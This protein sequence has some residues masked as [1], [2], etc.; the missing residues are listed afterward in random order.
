MQ[1]LEKL[2][3]DQYSRTPSPGVED[4]SYAHASARVRA[5]ETVMLGKSLLRD[6][7]NAQNFEDSVEMLT[8]TEYA[9]NQPFT[10]ANAEQKL[11]DKRAQNKNLFLELMLDHKI[12]ELILARADFA[13]MRLALRRV[14][15]DRPIGHDYKSWGNVQ[16][17]EFEEIFETERYDRLPGYL[18]EGV[19]AAV[20][21]YYQDKDIRQIDY[22]IDR[23]EMAYRL[24][25]A[26]EIKNEFLIN[27]FMIKI[28]L[29]NIK[30]L[31]R[32]K[33]AQDQRKDLF[34][35]GGF[36][37][38]DRLT[39]ALEIGYEALG[40]LFY[41]TL[42]HEVI[43]TGVSY[44]VNENSFL[45]LEKAI[46]DY[47]LGFLKTTRSI[48]A[49]PQPVIAYFVAKEMEIRTLRMV[50]TGKRHKL[51]TKLLVDRMPE[52]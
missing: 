8:S 27:F 16:P 33:M 43:E 7:A 49:G 5:L 38:T 25:T 35:E 24:Q 42:Y 37:L 30:T 26:K 18:H 47:I 52:L 14:L 48:T 40:Q 19:E 6:M 23:H 22:Q 10:L 45:K 41:P 1:N 31:L 50:L 34:F 17:E 32:L 3:L 36:V 11:V 51:M 4:W 29:Q 13:N 44:L 2:Q 39:H 21:A 20:L 46:D 9:L 28:D 12:A 15:T